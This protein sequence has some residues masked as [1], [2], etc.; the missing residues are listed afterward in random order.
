MHVVHR[1]HARKEVT[2]CRHWIDPYNE[3]QDLGEGWAFGVRLSLD[4]ELAEFRQ[5]IS[6]LDKLLIC[7]A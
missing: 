3:W 2:L 5:E 6:M 4:E 1:P 7:Q